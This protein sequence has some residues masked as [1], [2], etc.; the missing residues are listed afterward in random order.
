MECNLAVSSNLIKGFQSVFKTLGD[1][2]IILDEFQNV[3][4]CNSTAN[5]ILGNC[6]DRLFIRQIVK[7]FRFY[8][9]DRDREFKINSF[10]L[11][12][13]IKNQG[14]REL[15][16][17]LY[18]KK[19]GE[20]IWIHIFITPLKDKKKLFKGNT[21]I[22]RDISQTELPE[23]DLSNNIFIDRLT[24]CHNRKFLLQKI[25]S[26]LKK[27]RQDRVGLFA[28]ILLDLDR[29]KIVN[30]SLGH[31]IGDKLLIAL[32]R[33]LESCLR[34]GDLVVRL[35][36]DEF[37]IFL[38]NIKNLNCATQITD[39]IYKEL[40]LPFNLNEN[41]IFVDVSI[42]IAISNLNYQQSHEILRDADLAMRHAKKLGKSCYQVFN[43]EMQARAMEILKIENDLRRAIE[44]DEFVLHYQP[45][46]LLENRTI[47]GFEALL[48][49]QHPERGLI[50]PSEFIS[51][52]EETGLINT[53]GF[54]VLKEACYQMKL[55]Q[56]QFFNS[57]LTT[58]S[59]NVSGKQFLKA[60]FINRVQN[61]LKE[62]KLNPYC[63]KLEITESILVE[64]NRSILSTIEQ[65][66]NL[67]VQLSMDDFGTGYSSLSYL[68]HFPINTLKIDRSF[69]QRMNDNSQNLGIIRAIVALAFNLK[70]DVVAEGI[71][72][73]SQLAQLKRENCQRTAFNTYRK[74]PTRI[75]RIKARKE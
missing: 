56:S 15:D 60:D 6:N 50:Y 29:F 52:A 34:Q 11:K 53:I 21:I 68:H 4:F 40:I 63:L 66:K 64:N 57:S 48:R 28:I 25:E 61:I 75:R 24:G 46:I 58:I 17:Y 2:I 47:I 18:H 22:G 59:V 20:G 13:F 39:R 12:D 43:T 27:N 38:D 67:G 65:L 14:I 70:M 69:V 71:E 26:C 5:F 16:L 32:S 49:W 7:E 3:V 36:G 42:G 10:P 1:A 62:T 31:E 45:I 33:R 51:I 8:N 55:W 72:T 9:C 44:R 30:D 19:S 74:T 41:E 73:A 35:D 37:A 54:W 23:T